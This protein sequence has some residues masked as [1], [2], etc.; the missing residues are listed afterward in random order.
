MTRQELITAWDDFARKLCAAGARLMQEAQF[1][2]ND[3]VKRTATALVCRTVNN[4]SGVRLLLRR[5]LLVEGRTITRSCYENLFWIAGLTTKG[6][7]FIQLMSNDS[8]VSKRRLGNDLKEFA[9]KQGHVSEETE[10]LES[11]LDGLEATTK[12]KTGINN[13]EEAEA[14]NL[15]DGY[16]IYRALSGDAAHPSLTSL[17]RHIDIIGEDEQL[18]I[19]GAAMLASDDEVEETLQLACG[20]ALGVFS[21]AN[22][23]LGEVLPEDLTQLYEEFKV[24]CAT[25]AEVQEPND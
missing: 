23:L 20:A 4:I 19:R 7:A 15:K 10:K 11:F 12:G 24:L 9:E 5:G 18:Q 14:A 2:K 21:G 22:T 8:D 16:T 3:L 6:D 1:P 25:K 17:S 13:K